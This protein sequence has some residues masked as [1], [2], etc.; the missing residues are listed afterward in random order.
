MILSKDVLMIT[1]GSILQ[2]KP[3]S[4]SQILIT[5]FIVFSTDSLDP[6]VLVC[7]HRYMWIIRENRHGQGLCYLLTNDLQF[8]EVYEPCKG[9]TLK[10]WVLLLK[11]I[12]KTMFLRDS[13]SRNLYKFQS[14]LSLYLSLRNPHYIYISE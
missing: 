3:F 1:S 7:A 13:F 8:E 10:R 14:L 12:S 11:V 4:I 9:R 6:Q 2:K 5:N